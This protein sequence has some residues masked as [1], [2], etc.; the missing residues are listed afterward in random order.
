MEMDQVLGEFEKK[1]T[2][3]GREKDFFAIHVQLN[4]VVGA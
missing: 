2:K 4:H 1:L 3:E